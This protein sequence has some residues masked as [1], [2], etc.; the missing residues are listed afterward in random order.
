MRFPLLHLM[1]MSIADGMEEGRSRR[2]RCWLV[3]LT[4]ILPVKILIRE[5]EEEEEERQGQHGM[6]Y[7]RENMRIIF[8][9]AMHRRTFPY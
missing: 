8:R 5:K 6:L 9:K 1:E 7:G 4:K 2:F 3:M